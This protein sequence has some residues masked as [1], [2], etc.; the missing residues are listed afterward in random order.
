ME[1]DMVIVCHCTDCQKQSGSAFGLVMVV[2]EAGF[3]LTR[4]SVKTF[5][6]VAASG[7]AKMGAFC[8]DCGCRIY[9]KNAARVG[10]VSVRAGTLDDTS[11]LEPVA[12]IWTRDKQP[13]VV[14]PEGVKTVE[15]QPG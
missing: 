3:A 5:D 10:K 9:H 8:P 6:G 7:R 4:G 12:H 14:I 13:W 11:G 1:P 15:G 2:D